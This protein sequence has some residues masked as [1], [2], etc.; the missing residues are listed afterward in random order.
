MEI[1]EGLN[2]PII[3]IY[4]TK[5]EIGMSI[6]KIVSWSFVAIGCA[7]IIVY[8]LKLEN[9]FS[10]IKSSDQVRLSL[11]NYHISIWIGWVI[12]TSS[13]TY[14]Q[15]TQKKY[16][17]FVLDYLLVILAFIFFRHYL[18]LG[19]EEQFWSL[20]SSFKTGAN[21]TSMRNAL[22]MIFMTAFVQAAIKL[23]SSKWHRK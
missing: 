18:S 11:R 10:E 20:G 1:S 5:I 13:A 9:A 23:F 22:V 4:G 16:I 8:L 21:F 19:E 2:Q 12:V 14:Y 6:K 7:I 3:N 17:I 15:W